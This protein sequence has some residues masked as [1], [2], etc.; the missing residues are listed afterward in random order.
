MSWAR[1]GRVA[2]PKR[3]ADRA[4]TGAW[5]DLAAVSNYAEVLRTCDRHLPLLHFRRAWQAVRR[6]FRLPRRRDAA[7]RSCT[8]CAGASVSRGWTRSARPAYRPALRG[9]RVARGDWRRAY[10]ERR[11][12]HGSA[13]EA[14]GAARRLHPSARGSALPATVVFFRTVQTQSYGSHH[15]FPSL[16]ARSPHRTE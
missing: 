12:G 9:G 1:S 10:L 13:L 7:A 2:G 14:R 15:S 5:T 8:V 11:E 16:L 6:S 4:P 3:Q